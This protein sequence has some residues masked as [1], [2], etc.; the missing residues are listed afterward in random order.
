[1]WGAFSKGIA[2]AVIA[3][4]IAIL[5]FFLFWFVLP[6]H[7]QYSL[8]GKDEMIG[9]PSASQPPWIVYWANFDGY[10]YVT[11]ARRGYTREQVAFLPLYPWLIAKTQAYINTPSVIAGHLVSFLA[12]VGALT[13]ALLLLQKEGKS[14]LA[15]LFVAVI[16]LF[17]TSYSYSAVYNDSLFF[18][19]ATSCLYF[20]RVRRWLLASLA[21]ALAMLT[22]INGVALLPFL[23]IEYLDTRQVSPTWSLN[24]YMSAFSTHLHNWRGHWKVIFFGFIPLPFLGYLLFLQRTYGAWQILFKSMAQWGQDKIIFPLQTIVR[25]IKIFA[26]VNPAE[27][28]YWIAVAEIGFFFFYCIMLWWLWKKIRPSYWV[29]LCIS[30][31]IPALTG[32]FQGMPR[33]ALH[34]YPFFL[35]ITLWLLTKPRPLRLV[36]LAVSFA[37]Y[38]IFVTLFTHG[39]FVA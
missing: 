8:Y 36:Y 6:F 11:V 30:T 26:S 39:I 3:K 4:L 31:L 38:I 22:R 7:N 16:L 28:V 13:V 12:L 20:A 10:H 37:L 18:F 15:S 23:L 14:H 2:L 25:Y 1:M 32:T 34:L 24:Y 19:L 5:V 29:F 17:P 33:Y 21:G 9:R 35:G 27:A